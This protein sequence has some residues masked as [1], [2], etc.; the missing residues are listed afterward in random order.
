ML[1]VG[2]V[3]VVG[4]GTLLPA[5]KYQPS[6]RTTTATA[7]AM[8]MLRWFISTSHLKYLWYVIEIETQAEQRGNIRSGRAVAL[9][10]K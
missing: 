5:K 2:G 4:A 9:A 10:T 8:M 7:M 6:K 1:V 3:E